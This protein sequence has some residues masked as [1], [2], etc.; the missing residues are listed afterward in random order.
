MENDPQAREELL[1]LG[2]RMVP[3]TLV[4]DK[5]VTG[6]NP[7]ALAR[8]LGL[9][10]EATARRPKE[11]T[12]S[13]FDQVLEAVVRAVR[14]VPPERLSWHSPDR[15]RDMRT[16]M[17]HIFFFL[18]YAMEAFRQGRFVVERVA[19]YDK[20]AL[21]FPDA[22]AIARYGEDVRQRLH[23]FLAHLTDA[24]LARPIESYVGK[25]DYATQLELALGHSAQHLRHLYAY[26]EMMGI[27]PQAPLTA[28]D[29]E[30]LPV[31]TLLW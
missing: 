28:Q 26:L 13:K 18:E 6:F 21:R 10:E 3:V 7:R 1:S 17:A 31:P 19:E 14:Q 25:I 9:P 30:G 24:D 8:L 2:Y 5:A 15:G 23:R 12:L 27:Q 22:E 20:D 4:G 29:M 16:F 11:W